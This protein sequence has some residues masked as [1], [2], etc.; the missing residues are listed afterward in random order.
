MIDYILPLITYLGLL[1]LALGGVV[2]VV[3][4][5][6][7]RVIACLSLCNDADVEDFWNYR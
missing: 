3:L 7:G 6:L 4:K 1:L 2:Y 5:A